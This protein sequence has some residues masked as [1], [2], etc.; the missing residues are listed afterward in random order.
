[1]GGAAPRRHASFSLSRDGLCPRESCLLGS[2][3]SYTP[4]TLE[5]FDF[6]NRC[7]G[8]ICGCRLA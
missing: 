6:K 5:R 1:M 2:L 4:L 8:R 3:V 7:S